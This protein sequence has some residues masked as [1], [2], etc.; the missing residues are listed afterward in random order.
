MRGAKPLQGQAPAAS[1]EFVARV[2]EG[3]GSDLYRNYV[4][5]AFKAV[6]WSLKGQ[7][8]LHSIQITSNSPILP[9]E[10]VRPLAPGRYARRFPRH[11]ISLG[12]LGAA[13]HWT[14]DRPAAGPAGLHRRGD[15]RA[16]LEQQSR[17]AVQKV[18]VDALSKLAG[19]RLV[20][21]DFV[22]FEKMIGEVSTGFI[23]F[24]GHG[25][26]DDLGTGSPVFAIQLLDQAL[27]PI[28]WAR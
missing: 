9:W 10:L 15:R 14:T 5:G 26:V 4:A 13:Q 19:F 21:G 6:F 27:D 3:F 12:T 1:K 18:E 2:A 16:G 20:S 23:H 17:S 7:D 22:S 24:S 11:Q 8:L 28:T 25:E